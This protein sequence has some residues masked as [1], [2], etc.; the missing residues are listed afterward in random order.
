MSRSSPKKSAI[1]REATKLF[2]E[3]GF[4]DTSINDISRATGVA[5]GTIFYHFHSKEELFIAVLHNFKQELISSF[6]T[7]LEKRKHSTGLEMLEDVLSFYISQTRKMEERF[8]LLHRHHYYQL[9]GDNP[10]CRQQLKEIY[11][12]LISIFEQA[13]IRGQEDHS[14]RPVDAP[15]KALLIFTLVDGLVRLNAYKLYRAD[16]CHD[17]LIDSCR[18]MLQ[19]TT[20]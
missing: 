15:K 13:I 14:I 1:L 16:A 9:A 17:E 8:L 6:A 4:W 3:H 19:P 10:D 12:S 2:S 18:R 11:S 5:D 20:F 7:Y